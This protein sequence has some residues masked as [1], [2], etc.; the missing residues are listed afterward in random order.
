M[1]SSF[2]KENVIIVAVAVIIFALILGMFIFVGCTG[3][4][5]NVDYCGAEYC[6][7]NAKKSYKAGEK[8]TLYFELIATDTDYS[9]YLDGERINYDYDEKKG[10]IITFTMPNHDVKLECDSRNTMTPYAE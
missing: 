10:F 4:T 9:F 2:I 6:Y 5:Y 8:V 1:L 7:S 3:G